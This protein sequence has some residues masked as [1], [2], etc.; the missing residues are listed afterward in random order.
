MVLP[1]WGDHEK[2]AITDLDTSRASEPHRLRGS[3]PRGSFLYEQGNRSDKVWSRTVG[4]ISYI[5]RCDLTAASHEGFH[6][7][8]RESNISMCW[9][10]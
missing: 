10:I 9:T 1:R 2:L 4:D 7:F 8:G 6:P 3:T 5:C